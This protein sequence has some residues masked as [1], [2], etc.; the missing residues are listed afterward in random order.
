[1]APSKLR[2]PG[3]DLS[4]EGGNRSLATL[5]RAMA[6]EAFTSTSGLAKPLTLPLALTLT[7]GTVRSKLFRSTLSP[8][9]SSLKLLTRLMGIFLPSTSAVSA[10]S[11]RW[12]PPDC[13]EKPRSFTSKP[14]IAVS[15]P[16]PL[17]R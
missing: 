9:R 5:A 10:T 2:P 16:L 7:L 17:S 15:V 13:R 14:S 12:S 6:T 1:M 3:T 11:R 8:G 4:S